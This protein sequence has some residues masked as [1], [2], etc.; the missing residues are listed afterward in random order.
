MK[1]LRI[2]VLSEVINYRS[3]ARAALEIGKRLS[4]L[5][6]EVTMFGYDF[7][8]DQTTVEDLHK[9]GTHIKFITKNRIPFIGKYLS[10]IDLYKYIRN[11]SFD[12]IFF[13]GTLPFF[14]AAKVTGVPITRMYQGTQFDAF[15]E[16]KTP[17]Q[18]P[19]LADIFINSLANAYIYLNELIIYRLSDSVVGISKFAAREGKLLYQ[20][21]CDEVIYH[22]AGFL[23][24][25]STGQSK[26]TGVFEIISVSR[27][28]PYK[29]F[30]LI[31]EAVK[32]L[33]MER[34]IHITI[35]GS[36]P[37]GNY[38]QYLKQLGG[39]QVK[40]VLN[41]SDYELA[42][43]YEHADLCATA[44]RYLYFGLPVYEAAFFG[45]PTVALDF[46]AAR[47]VVRHGKTGF[48]AK[49]IAEFSDYIGKLVDNDSLRRSLG[50]N[51]KKIAQQATWDLCVRAWES[52]MMRIV[53]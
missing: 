18:T 10:S 52:E 7:L 5:G 51:A 45:K 41:P 25:K 37:K 31:L 49:N 35:V 6:H 13:S 27:I 48:V 30:H 39:K 44:D 19:S 21:A 16:R 43:V 50:N 29:G 17:D 2:G 24:I 20:R 40:I 46:A 26:L 28:T 3:G 8:V 14:L 34:T 15:L 22:G 32:L 11:N 12:V 9:N 23:P 4:K 36:Q 38:V 33:N 53:H 47:E 1:T 42:K